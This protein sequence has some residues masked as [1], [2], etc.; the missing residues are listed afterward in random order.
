MRCIG[1]LLSWTWCDVVFLIMIVSCVGFINSCFL[2]EDFII[3]VIEGLLNI[4]SWVCR[5]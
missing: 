3:Y 5:V 4:G 1:V 2:H